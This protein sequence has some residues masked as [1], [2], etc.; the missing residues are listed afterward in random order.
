[1]VV[2][3]S[4]STFVE[5]EGNIFASEATAVV[6]T[7]NCVGVMGAGIAL[8]AR[9]RWPEVFEHYRSACEAGEVRPGRVNWTASAEGRQIVL[10]PTKAHW[11]QPSRLEYIRGGLESLRRDIEERGV[12]H[13]AMPRLGCSN[14]GLNWSSVRPLIERVLGG[15]PGG[16]F[17]LW[18]FRP[19]FEDEQLL[20]LR[21]AVTSHSIHYVADWLDC[22]TS[23]ARR[24]QDALS[25]TSIRN[26][27]SLVEKSGVGEQVA[28]AA[29]RSISR[30]LPPAQGALEI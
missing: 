3:Q 7:V 4:S 17:E 6:I 30:Q 18:S 23:T 29:Y 26:F 5:S 21:E 2:E 24:L 22:S 20:N 28:A 12:L 25:D 13:I 19:N 15:V 9:Y 1:M 10:F 27:P 14:G 11:R 16:R 8:D